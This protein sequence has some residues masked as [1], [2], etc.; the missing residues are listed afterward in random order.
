MGLFKF[1]HKNHEVFEFLK[2]DVLESRIVFWK[3]P[4]LILK[5]KKLEL[6]VVIK[7]NQMP[8]A[9]L[10]YVLQTSLSHLNSYF[11]VNQGCQKNK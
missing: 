1:F 7:K 5:F 10:W 8:S 6:R 2:L 4:E 9:S 11:T 3:K